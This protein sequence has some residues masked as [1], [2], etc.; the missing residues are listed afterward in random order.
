MRRRKLLQAWTTACIGMPLATTWARS[1]DGQAPAR[2]EGA[3]RDGAIL[4]RALMSIERVRKGDATIRFS[5]LGERERLGAR[6]E[7]RQLSH[8]FSFGNIL[9]YRHFQ[10]SEV[11]A[12][13]KELFNFCTLLNFNWAQHEP[14]QG[15]TLR[16]Q[17]MQIALW[18]RENNITPN[19]H[20][21][22]WTRPSGVPEWLAPYDEDRKYAMLESR[23]KD[24]VR[25]FKGTIDSWVVVNEPINVRRWGNWNAPEWKKDERIED[26]APYVHDAFTWSHQAN[27]QATLILNEYNLIPANGVRDRFMELVRE[28]KRRGTP[29]S[30]LGIQGHEPF[31]GR[32]WYSPSEIWEALDELATLGYPLYITEFMPQARGNIEGGHRRGEWTPEVQAEYAELFYKTCFGHP[33]VSCIIWFGMMDDENDAWG[34]GGVLDAHLRPKPV[35][36]TLKKLIHEEWTT[37]LSSTLGTDGTLRFRGFFGRYEIILRTADGR[38]HAFQIHLQRGGSNRWTLTMPRE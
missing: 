19:G 23:V 7:V 14:Q 11:R 13:F 5:G 4:E 22:V 35:F 8:D 36:H 3:G 6:V 16:D 26:V 38:Q 21:L 29:I 9:R 17:K 31:V 12:R 20:M 18:C 15:Q 33:S 30:V 1:F 27:P 10:Q 34:S 2:R 28:L 32:Y 37:R 24:V 25:Q